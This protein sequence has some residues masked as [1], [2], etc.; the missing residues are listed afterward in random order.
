[1]TSNAI[2]IVYDGVTRNGG[3]GEGA[4]DARE[5][6]TPDGVVRD[7]MGGPVTVDPVVAISNGES[8]DDFATSS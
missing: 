6:I 2:A 1:M 5:S 7:R 4:V 3:G 8:T